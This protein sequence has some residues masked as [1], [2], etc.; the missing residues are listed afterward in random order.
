LARCPWK[1]IIAVGNS[2]SYINKTANRIRRMFKWGVA[3]ELV[4]VQVHQALA[5]LP[6][7]KKGKTKAREADPVRKFQV[8]GLRFVVTLRSDNSLPKR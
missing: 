4:P 5:A 6:G 1:Q 3:K 7:L 8:V 2:R